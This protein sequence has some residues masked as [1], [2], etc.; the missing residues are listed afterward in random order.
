MTNKRITQLPVAVGL[1]GEEYLAIDQPDGFGGYVT[2]RT[3]TADVA[4]LAE[5]GIIVPLEI[6]ATEVTFAAPGEQ[7]SIALGNA[8]TGC[9]AVYIDNSQNAGVFRLTCVGGANLLNQ[10]PSNSVGM[11]PVLT[12]PN[13]LNFIAEDDLSVATVSLWFTNQVQSYF[14]YPVV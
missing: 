1:S 10:C 14:S 9:R 13:A 3:T 11:F 12:S 2:R 7:I 5:S 6:Y 8:M 4:G